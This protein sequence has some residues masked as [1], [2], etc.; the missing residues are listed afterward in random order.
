MQ[1]HATFPRMHRLP[2]SLILLLA[3]VSSA[4]AQIMGQA[5]PTG[6]L[7]FAWQSEIEAFPTQ[8]PKCTQVS[9]DLIIQEAEPGAIASLSPLKQIAEIA[10]TLQISDNQAL[11]SLAGLEGLRSVSGIRIS[12]NQALSHV[13]ALMGIG[14]IELSLRVAR[15]SSLINLAGLSQLT[16]VGGDLTLTDNDLLV[17]LEGLQQLQRIGQHLILTSNAGLRDLSGLEQLAYIGK[18]LL[19]KDNSNLRSLLGLHHLTAIGEDL[20]V[21]NNPLLADFQGLNAL[22]SVGSNMLVVNLQSLV[23]FNGLQALTEIGGLLQVFNNGGLLRLTGI[24]SIDHRS[25]TELVLLESPQLADCSV[26]SICDF[27]RAEEGTAT[28]RLN[29]QGCQTV[30]EVRMQCPG[31]GIN[32]QPGLRGQS[33]FYP[34]PTSGVLFVRHSDLAAA[35]YHIAGIAGRSLATGVVQSGVIDLSLLPSAAYVVELFHEGI[36]QRE[37]VLKIE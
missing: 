26:R 31:P 18:E 8:F 28:I 6:D 3:L 25:I 23:D 35:S 37:L 19:V 5:C 22:R 9:G 2:R 11:H 32:T 34:N 14:E 27:L 16:F 29:A 30:Q 1:A 21:D 33:L 24:D 36:H 10:G 17:N 4:R 15:N 20:I 13:D 7:T 12:S